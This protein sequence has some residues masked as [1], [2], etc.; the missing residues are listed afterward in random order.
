MS[1]TDTENWGNTLSVYWQARGQAHLSGQNFIWGRSPMKQGFMRYL[2]EQHEPVAAL[3]N[4]ELFERANKECTNSVYPHECKGAWAYIRSE[5]QQDTQAA[6]DRISKED[7]VEPP[8]FLPGDVVLHLRLEFDHFQQAWPARSVFAHH[9]PAET[10]RIRILHQPYKTEHFAAWKPS[11][12]LGDIHEKYTPEM[13]H[14]IDTVLHGYKKMLS[15]VCPSCSVVTETGTQEGDFA[16]IARAP[17]FF[18]TGSTYGFWAAMGNNRGEVYM[19]PHF[20]AGGGRPDFGSHW[21]WF[22]GK[23]FKNDDLKNFAK[24]SAAQLADWIQNN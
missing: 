18:G 4:H 23:L 14:N 11:K 20:H 22:Q 9:L 7:S 19:S 2:P 1:L 24:I 17:V 3:T 10:K 15:S 13:Q 21:H 5:I 6:L 16:T 12:V 8:K